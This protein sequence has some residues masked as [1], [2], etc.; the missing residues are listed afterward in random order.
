MTSGYNPSKT[1]WLNPNIE[2][3]FGDE[4]I[5]YDIRDAGFNIVKQYRLLPD[6]K[7]RE[8]SMMQKGELRHIAIGKL[9]RDDKDFSN[10]L[11]EKFTEVRA[12]FL[13]AN[14]LTDDNIIS[15]K[16]DA[17]YTIG[18]CNR[19]RFGN[20]EFAPKNQ[21][22]SYVRF[23][24]INNLEVY[25]SSEKIDIKGMGDHAVNRHRLYMFDF[26]RSIIDMIENNDIRVKRKIMRFISD[27]KSQELD[28]EFYVEF[29]NM[30]REI[31]PLFNYKNI[32][33]PLVQ[34]ILKEME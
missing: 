29:N 11:L 1:T 12:I 22:S 7:I 25:Y 9:Q 28:E 33:L 30:S 24:D 21:Y 14:N 10:R 26:I 18:P 5:E 23:P 2:Y 8:L 31:N 34:I 27:Y 20:I 15:V 32:I 4:I 19:L 6:T 16:K 13:S 17:I 3:L